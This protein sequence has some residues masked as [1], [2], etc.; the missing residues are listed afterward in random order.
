MPV[1]KPHKNEKEN[2]F[3]SRCIRTLVND[4]TVENTD[5]GR[6]QAAAICHES[7]DQSKKE[8]IAMTNTNRMYSILQVKSVDAE[9]RQIK[10]VA[11]TPTPD[12]LGDVIE[13]KGV[14]FKNP[15]PLLWQHKHDQPVG[16]AK[17][18]KA[19]PD[20]IEFEAQLPDVKEAGK[21]QDRVNE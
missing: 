12:R 17:F 16:W 6:S 3:I 10:G 18:D 5:K 4:G 13:P 19:T 2:D 1:P 11:T 15:M 7:W 20:G 9:R 14:Q 8:V 21:L